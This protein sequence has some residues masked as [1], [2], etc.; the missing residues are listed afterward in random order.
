MNNISVNLHGYCSK[1]VNLYNYIQT[2]VSKLCKFF[3]LLMILN[4]NTYKR[5]V[6]KKTNFATKSIKCF[7]CES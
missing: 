5:R 7:K 3:A 1:F 6:K 2:N 4:Q